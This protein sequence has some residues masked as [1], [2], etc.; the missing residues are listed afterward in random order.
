MKCLQCG[1]GLD[2]YDK[3]LKD[4]TLYC[5][6]GSAAEKYAKDHKLNYEIEK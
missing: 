6:K 4:F 5:T 2:D 1:I 3:P